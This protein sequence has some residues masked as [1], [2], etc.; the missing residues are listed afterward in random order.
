MPSNCIIKR[1]LGLKFI[2]FIPLPY[3]AIHA[4]LPPQPTFQRE[5]KNASN[6]G[7]NHHT[8]SGMQ[9][10]KKRNTQPPARHLMERL[11]F[12]LPTPQQFEVQGC[13]QSLTKKM[14][15]Q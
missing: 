8:R 9:V 15:P 4:P 2:R 6:I 7:T 13:E 1:K 12:L 5:T 11:D 10:R 3:P 14:L